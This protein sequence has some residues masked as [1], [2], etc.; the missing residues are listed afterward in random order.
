MLEEYRSSLDEWATDTLWRF[1]ER[2]H[3][4]PVS[5]T[6]SEIDHS[7]DEQTESDR[8][9]CNR[10]RSHGDSGSGWSVPFDRPTVPSYPYDETSS[11]L[12]GVRPR[13]NT[14]NPVLTV[15]DVTDFGNAHFVAD[16]FLMG[17]PGGTLH[18]FF[19]V[20]NRNR[21]PTAA[22][23]HATSTDE[24]CTWSYDGIVLEESDHLSFPYVFRYAGEY[25]MIPDKWD[26]EGIAPIDLYRADS[27]PE[28]W[29]R[30]ARL[31]APDRPLH[32]FVAFRWRDRWWGV[33]GDGSD[34]TVFHA[35]ELERDRWEPHPE[36]PVV[37]DR[38]RGARPA[39]R[40]LVR[41]DH[42]ELF[43]QDCTS[44]YGK[45]VRAFRIRRLS[46][47]E[48]DDVELEDSPLLEPTEERFGW[49]SGRMHHVDAW[50]TGEEWVCAVD[51]NVNFRLGSFGKYHW[52]IGLYTGTESSPNE[53]DPSVT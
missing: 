43:V 39:G 13:E 31:V 48:Y 6:P 35:D 47:S 40:P 44:Q 42:V 9:P 21:T 34:M 30:V 46:R 41:R 3:R 15:D 4:R 23:G 26:R 14:G 53:S 25:Y 17:D 29:T 49:N 32:D 37:T 11:E 38:P 22:I 33:A 12:T 24:G 16:P 8:A 5:N 2:L 1:G 18:M 51:G 19:E 7:R 27:F 50:Y 36:N 10:S 45:R 20:F 52:S 28:E